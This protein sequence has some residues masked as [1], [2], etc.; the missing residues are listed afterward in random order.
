MGDCLGATAAV[1]G[2]AMGDA[3]GDTVTA[4]GGFKVCP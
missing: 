3:M 1:R 4:A 2:D